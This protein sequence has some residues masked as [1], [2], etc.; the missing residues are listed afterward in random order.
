MI[1]GCAN[2]YGY[3]NVYI[4]KAKIYCIGNATTEGMYIAFKLR[5]AV[6]NNGYVLYKNMPLIHIIVNILC[7]LMDFIIN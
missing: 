5:L 7:L 2:I 3:I 6:S 1:E 4:P